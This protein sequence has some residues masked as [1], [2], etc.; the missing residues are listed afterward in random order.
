MSTARNFA[1]PQQNF[2]LRPG[3]RE[4]FSRVANALRVA[5]FTETVVHGALERSGASTPDH[6]P[7]QSNA[8]PLRPDG[9]LF[10]RLFVALKPVL[11]SDLEQAL[12]HATLDA[13]L[14]LDLIRV[15][16]SDPM[17]YVSPIFLYPVGESFVASDHYKNPAG[18][19][20]SPPPDVVF[21]AVFAGT[22]QFLKLLPQKP[23]GDGLDLCTGTG[24]GALSLSKNGQHVVASDIT[25]RAAHFA[26]FNRLLNGCNNVEAVQGDLYASVE[27][28]TF[29]LVIAHPPYMP[30]AQEPQ[31]WRDGG[32]TGEAILQRI[33]QE[34][35]KYLRPRGLFLTVC[36]GID[37]DQTPLQDR[38][39]SWLGEAQREFD[40]IVAVQRVI[41]PKQL[42]KD[43]AERE[44]SHTGSDRAVHL[45]KTFVE[46]GASNFVYGAFVLQRRATPASEPWTLRTQ[47]SSK[48]DGRGLEWTFEW[49]RRC[50][51]EG[52]A[53][54]LS[55]SQ[56]YLAPC[57]RVQVTHT[58][59]NR[60]LVPTAVVLESDWP[61]AAALKID[62]W[63]VPII[64]RFD[65]VQQVSAVY[66]NAR[67]EG[68][69]PDEFR[70]E[71]FVSVVTMLIMRG[72]LC[73]DGAT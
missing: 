4:E 30:S 65:G 54:H 14:S 55:S 49:H 12:D 43:I 46:F 10:V 42:A 7:S 52:F 27:G 45:E 6:E 66:A 38:L 37:T 17:Q 62:A 68:A 24:I 31:V 36:L 59:E 16:D 57:L 19:A 13:F 34:L 1:P 15:S 39:R 18:G 32:P 67:A 63:I 11:R 40:L 25:A 23:F 47:I 26:E 69:M 29:D 56:P 9:D 41:S 48:T 8:P 28:R 60:D 61:F 3:S 71:D 5:G 20:F 21:P 64:A 51:P 35:P 33:V 44:A 2:P 22:L 58:V 72:Y 50:L 53:E 70:L 73:L